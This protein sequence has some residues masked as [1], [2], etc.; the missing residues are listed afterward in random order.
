MLA[1]SAAVFG[2]G[3]Y[4]ALGLDLISA[5][6]VLTVAGGI[7]MG[8]CIAAAAVLLFMGSLWFLLLA[9]ADDARISALAWKPLVRPA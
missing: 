4:L 6:P 7:L 3:V 2:L 1:G 5:I 8:V 9:G